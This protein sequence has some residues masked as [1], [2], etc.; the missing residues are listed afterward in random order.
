[1]EIDIFLL[2]YFR[3]ERALKMYKCKNLIKELNLK[4]I[5]SWM[6]LNIAA[7]WFNG[8]GKKWTM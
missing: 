3:L 8:N 1:M 2:S 5:L 4:P 6:F 7:A